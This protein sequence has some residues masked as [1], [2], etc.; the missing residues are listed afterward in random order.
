[1]TK[2]IECCLDD[3]K[4]IDPDYQGQKFYHNGEKVKIV[5]PDHE[6]YQ[7]IGKYQG[8]KREEYPEPDTYLIEIKEAVQ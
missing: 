4:S 7:S 6:H 3:F 5:N 2:I 8:Y 1:M